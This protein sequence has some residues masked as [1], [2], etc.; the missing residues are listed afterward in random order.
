MHFNILFH[1][2]QILL[3]TTQKYKPL[4]KTYN[5]DP[6]DAPLVSYGGIDAMMTIDIRNGNTYHLFVH[7]TFTIST[8]L[9]I[10]LSSESDLHRSTNPT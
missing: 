10:I 1:P 7:N 5:Y 3:Q 9:A 4:A 8:T 2:Y 6:H